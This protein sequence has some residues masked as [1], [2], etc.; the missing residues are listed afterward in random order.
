MSNS[1]KHT[2]LQNAKQILLSYRKLQGHLRR[3]LVE[4]GAWFLA[5]LTFFAMIEIV[6]WIAASF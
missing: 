4:T 1:I 5:F 2:Q 3:M 6:L